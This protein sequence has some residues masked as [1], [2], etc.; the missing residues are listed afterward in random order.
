MSGATILT[1]VLEI[2]ILISI[3]YYAEMLKT[4]VKRA[5]KE[6]NEIDIPQ[7]EADQLSPFVT[8]Y[9]V[10]L[11]TDKEVEMQTNIESESPE[12]AIDK[13]IEENA[14]DIKRYDKV[15]RTYF[16]WPI[17]FQEAKSETKEY[18]KIDK[19]ITAKSSVTKF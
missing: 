3:A 10:G 8:N 17:V 11:K 14:L 13:W 16:G 4:L 7:K 9:I 2:V 1:I 6:I 19:K 5:I 12:D 18:I 15:K